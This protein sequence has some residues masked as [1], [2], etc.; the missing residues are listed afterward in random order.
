MVNWKIALVVVIVVVLVMAVGMWLGY[1]YVSEQNDIS[2]EGWRERSHTTD[3]HL[4][5]LYV[6]APPESY[7]G[8]MF[9]FVNITQVCVFLKKGDIKL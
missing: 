8:M 7:I 3:L 4:D 6:L 2:P 5:E 9:L 1:R